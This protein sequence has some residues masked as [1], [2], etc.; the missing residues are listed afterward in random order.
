MES[1]PQNFLPVACA[2]DILPYALYSHSPFAYRWEALSHCL[3]RI[4]WQR[5]Y[6][7]GMDYETK[8]EVVR[9]HLSRLRIDPTT[10]LPMTMSGR[11]VRNVERAA[12]DMGRH[13]DQD[14]QN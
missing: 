11:R 4:Y 7:D 3:D 8:I 6:G 12:F 1:D 9:Q 10:I 5:L 14:R 13:G 2:F